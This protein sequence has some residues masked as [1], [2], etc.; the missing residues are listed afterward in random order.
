MIDPMGIAQAPSAPISQNV[1]ENDA[2][3]RDAFLRLLTVQLEN[4]DPLDPMKNEDFVAQLAQ[5]SSLEQLQNINQTLST[6]QQANTGV[7]QAVDS[8]TAVALIGREVEVPTD[9]VAY[10]GDGSLEIGYHVE[11]PANRVNLQ[12]VDAGGSLIRTL[13]ATSVEAGNASLQWDGRD[14][15]GRKA[16]AG[17][18]SVVPSAFNGQGEAVRIS[19]ALV[20]EVMGVRY[21]DGAPILTLD[22]GEVPLYG[23]AR[24]FQKR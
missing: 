16:L 3:G 6:D 9:T 15:E 21:E 17:T 19:A 23:V 24:V 11:G 2:L 14:A 20:G 5:F 7:R 1:L 8:N 4:Q 13:T 12:I 10:S 18:Y 22:G